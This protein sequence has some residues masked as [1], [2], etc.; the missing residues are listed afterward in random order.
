MQ[1]TGQ[2]STRVAAMNFVCMAIP[3]APEAMGHKSCGV[4]Q[5]YIGALT[6]GYSE[7]LPSLERHAGYLSFVL[8]LQ[9]DQAFQHPSTIENCCIQ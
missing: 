5:R 9:S 6:V 4:D 7:E 2:F 1:T 3:A 8:S